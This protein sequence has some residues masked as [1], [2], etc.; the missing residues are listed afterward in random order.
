MNEIDAANTSNTVEYEDLEQLDVPQHFAVN[1]DSSA[2]WVIRKILE[3]RAYAKRCGDWYE[4]EQARAKNQ[5]KFFLFRFGQQLQEYARR[6]IEAE[7]TRRKSISLPAGSLGFRH[8]GPKLIIDDEAAVIQWAKE[9]MPALVTT[10]DRL[11]KSS[12][13][14]HVAQ[15]GEVPEVGVHIEPAKE[16]FYIR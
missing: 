10:V 16:Q 11:S 8:E 2:N 9:H 13:N 1:D 3:C 15:T 5:E 12:L 14:D 7:R 4:G 6:K